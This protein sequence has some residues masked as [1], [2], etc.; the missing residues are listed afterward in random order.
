MNQIKQDILNKIKKGEIKK[1]S[2]WFFVTKDYFFK[3]LFGLSI[4]LG[5]IGFSSALVQLF[6]KPKNH[7]EMGFT[8]DWFHH[9]LIS[10]PYIWILFLAL[11]MLI[12]W[13]NYKNTESGYKKDNKTVI[14]VSVIISLILGG[15]LFATGAGKKVDD[16]LKNRMKPYKE[17]QELRM[18]QREQHLKRV[19][20]RLP[21]DRKRQI[22]N[23][24][25]EK[26]AE[27]INQ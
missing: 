13:F 25:R 14:L 11:F 9:F 18:K 16:E 17:F 1:T 27:R 2:P 22:L 12:G 7:M 23:S 3:I 19:I 8:T 5:S 15:A 24:V 6:V 26:R 21:E 4:I 20:E 10:A